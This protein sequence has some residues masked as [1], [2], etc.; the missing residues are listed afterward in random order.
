MPNASG[1]H[2][3]ASRHQAHDA[4]P[5]RRLRRA[6]LLHLDGD[7][8]GAEAAYADLLESEPDNAAALNNLGLLRAQR[9][10]AKG[11]IAAYD[12][13]GSEQDL[14]PT[15]LLNK[16]NAHLALADP[17]AAL[18]LLQRA[19]TLDP[20]SPAWV[21]LG[22]AHL[23]AGDLAAAEAT[24]RQAYE[25]LPARVEVLRSYAACL[26]N[27]GEVAEAAALLATAV[28]LDEQDASSWRQLGAVLLALRDLG[29]AA[30]STRN[31][32]RLEP[33]HV[34]TLRQLAVVLV[35]LD[36]PAEAAAQLDHALALE[37]VTDLLVD[38]AVL[39]LASGECGSA[40]D[41][42][43]EAVADDPSGRARL[44][45]A[46]ALLAAGRTEDARE[47]LMTVA[48]MSEPFAQQAREAV[49]R[50]GE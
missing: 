37:R 17:A 33:D 35:A 28:R 49:S 48:G 8:A 42:L 27:R 26:A 9:G 7:L 14:S 4:E 5:D 30:H 22:Q 45:L 16:A 40:L 18:P 1:P 21:T 29:S 34:P 39:H 11:A 47:Q 25:R 3:L 13:I 10:D 46:Y 24:L 31:A 44:H 19:V 36:R 15:A 38:R 41:L 6:V 20:Q 12:A 32:L 2:A 50:V 43:G 23:L